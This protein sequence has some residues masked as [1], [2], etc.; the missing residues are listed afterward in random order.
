VGSFEFS[1]DGLT[2][3]KVSRIESLNIQATVAA[4]QVGIFREP[5][6]QATA[7]PLPNLILSFSGD[8]SD[9]DAWL[10]A[11]MVQGQHLSSDEKNA[12]LTVKSSDPA[13]TMSLVF[14]HVGLVRYNWNAAPAD[15]SRATSGTLFR[16]V[17]AK[18][19]ATASTTGIHHQ[20]CRPHADQ[21]H[22]R[23][24]DPHHN[25]ANQRDHQRE[26]SRHRRS[27]RERGRTSGA[28]EPVLPA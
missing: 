3:N 21:S 10:D 25:R 20:G 6:V 9:W 13:G 8:L 19:G 14:S 5:T 23:Y 24:Q 11:W 18:F 2:G 15:G 28:A 17:T 22:H 7:L 12:Q 1:I 4:D 26:R 16:R 27:R